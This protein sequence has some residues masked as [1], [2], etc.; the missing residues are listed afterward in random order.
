MLPRLIPQSRRTV[1]LCLPTAG[2]LG[3]SHQMTALLPSQA[4]ATPCVWS[5]RLLPL[6]GPSCHV[7]MPVYVTAASPNYR[8][9][10]CVGDTSSHALQWTVAQRLWTTLGMMWVMKQYHCKVETGLQD[11]TT[12]ST[13]SLDL[14]KIWHSKSTAFTQLGSLVLLWPYGCCKN[15]QWALILYI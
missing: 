11:W 13:S 14:D 10:L 15:S 8:T 9:A 12:G 3:L 1:C 6:Q 5:V 7:D 2:H 4:A